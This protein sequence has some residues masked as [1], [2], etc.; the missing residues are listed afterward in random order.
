MKALTSSLS[1]IIVIILPVIFV[2]SFLFLPRGSILTRVIK[3]VKKNNNNKQI[4]IAP[5]GRN[6]RGTGYQSIESIALKVSK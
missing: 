1:L 6:F 5:L 2:F 4:C 3:N